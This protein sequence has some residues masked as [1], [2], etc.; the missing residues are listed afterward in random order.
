MI[1][2]G[3]LILAIWTAVTALVLATAGAALWLVE[4]SESES[5]AEA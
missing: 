2:S 1:H 3:R 4:R 5:I